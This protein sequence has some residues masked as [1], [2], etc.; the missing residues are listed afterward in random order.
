[1]HDYLFALKLFVRVAH[2]GSFSAAGRELALTQPSVSRTISS[3]EQEVGIQLLTRTTRA[4]ALTEA[5]A[6]FLARVESILSALEEAEQAA[7]GTGELRGVLRLGVTT[8]FALRVVVPLLPAFAE[9]HPALHVELLM[10]DQRQNLIADGVDVAVRYGP[11][12]DS[13]AM[14]RRLGATP[15]LLVAAPSY[16][17]KVGAPLSPRDL[18]KYRMISARTIAGNAWAFAKDG[19][20]V[21]VKIAEHMVVSVNEVSAAA[22]AAGLGIAS[23][24][25]SGCVQELR[26][27]TLVRLL[28]DWDMG[29]IEVNAVFSAGRASKPSAKAFVEFLRPKLQEFGIS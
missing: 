12:S 18:H 7:R 19:E 13:G 21:Q 26:A 10:N 11:L 15:R 23:L 28:P 9:L 24:S 14:A 5:G 16:I 3:L 2:T 29:S 1:M 20:T 25:L 27:G 6:D 4:V 8:S 22:A 17:A